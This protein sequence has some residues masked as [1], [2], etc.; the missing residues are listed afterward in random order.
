MKTEY[1]DCIKCCRIYHDIIFV[2]FELFVKKK[3]IHRLLDRNFKFSSLSS[4]LINDE[5]LRQIAES[6]DHIHIDCEFCRLHERFF[7]VQACDSTFRNKKMRNWIQISHEI[8]ENIIILVFRFALFFFF[9]M[10]FRIFLL[11]YSLMWLILR[12]SDWRMSL[13]LWCLLMNS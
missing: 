4:F 6:F 13:D 2:F 7:D 5:I 8:F 1:D 12:R 3:K 9:S 11:F 10:I